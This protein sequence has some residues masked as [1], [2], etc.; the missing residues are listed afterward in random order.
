M[1][2]DDAQLAVFQ[3]AHEALS[4]AYRHAHGDYPPNMLGQWQKKKAGGP[5]RLPMGLD[6]AMLAGWVRQVVEGG[7]GCTGLPEPYRSILLAKF[8]VDSRLNLMAKLRVL[9]DVLLFAMGTG[10]HKRRMV[11]LCVQRY[12]GGTMICKDGERRPI[13][14][15]QV[16][17]FCGVSQQTVSD[18]Y[19]KVRGWIEAKERL[20]M[21]LVERELAARGLVQ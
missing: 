19:I 17:E 13:R 15:W 1:M 18:T 14:Q 2:R 11:D 8:A 5:A 21:E 3:S 7:E 4:F 20:A 9:E 12:F 16:A 10:L 6:A